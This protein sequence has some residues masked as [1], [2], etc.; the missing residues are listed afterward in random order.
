MKAAICSTDALKVKRILVKNGFNIV[1]RNPGFVLCYGGDGTVL[2][3]ERLYPS[4]PKLIIKKTK[5]CRKYDYKLKD[6]NKI[7]KK[8][9]NKKF[10]LIKKTKLIANYKNDKLIALNEIQIHTKLPI[11]AIRFSLEVNGKEFENLIGDGAIVAT[12]F[13]STGYYSATGGKLFKKGIGISFNNLYSR[14]I[15]SIVVPNN[16]K[17]KIKII[18]DNA[19]LLADNNEKYF[20]LEKGDTITVEKHKRLAKFIQV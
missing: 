11:R 8:I 15:S 3:A 18:R 4:I 5:I 12:P 16:S 10:K 19:L 20:E 6:L 14:K 9:K 13:G 7:L 17:I 2:F 1:K